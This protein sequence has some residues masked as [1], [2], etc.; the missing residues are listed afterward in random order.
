LSEQG[1]NVKN[2]QPRHNFSKEE[3]MRKRIAGFGFAFIF[4]AAAL[5]LAAL[6]G[7]PGAQKSIAVMKFTV[8]AG[9][10]SSYWHS[11]SWDVGSGMAE[12]TTTALVESG[13]FRVLERQQIDDVIGEQDFGDSGRVD[14]A[15]AAK[16]GKILGAQYLL[17]GTVNEFEYSK[18]GEAGGV[19]IGG[20]RV[21][22]GQAKAHIGMD[23]RV[24]D[25]VTG[26]ILFSTRSTANAS[27][28]GFKVG[29]SGSDFGANVGAF[30]KT[31]MGEATRKAI[32]DAVAKLAREF[33]G[34]A[35]APPP[36]TWSGTL[37]VAEGGAL[38]IKA[39]TK[40]GL[41]TGDILT[42]YR[43]KTVNAGG[44]ILTVGEDKIGKIRLTTVG[45]SAAS[46]EAVEGSGFKTGDI[47]KSGG[48]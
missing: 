33:G 3:I 6:P 29:Y 23:V 8:T 45:E 30:R 43:P 1:K 10:G 21:G 14:P 36:V 15:T 25:A 12:M 9:S 35:A 44:E 4:L 16:I 39:G 32:D 38:V 31:P 13:Q 46:A 2:R 27:R 34:E 18:G 37:I 40:N 20:V 5:A 26:E 48:D 11:A 28:T 7:A 41:K 42:V 22:A 24:V 19:R 17:Y 47:V